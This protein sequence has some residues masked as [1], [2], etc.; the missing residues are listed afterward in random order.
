MEEAL[1]NLILSHG[2]IAASAGTRVDWGV[3]QQGA[4]LPSLNMYL[5]SGQPQMK[6]T[7]PAGWSR[8]RV[9]IDCMGR[10]FK[11]ARDLADFLAKEPTGLLL[12]WRGDHMGVR[13]RTIVMG[14]RS[15]TDT[16]DIGPVHRT[17]VDVMVWHVAIA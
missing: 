12:G 10:T 3:R 11:A 9:Q 8:D 6:F 14:R 7:G 4:P 1:R 15:D 2:G 17:S 5:I 16:D 13:M